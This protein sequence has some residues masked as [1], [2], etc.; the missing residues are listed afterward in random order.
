MANMMSEGEALSLRSAHVLAELVDAEMVATRCD[1]A[2][3]TQR[4][5]SRE[6]HLAAAY[7]GDVETFTTLSARARST[8]M[9]PPAGGTHER[10][11]RRAGPPRALSRRPIRDRSELRPNETLCAHL[12]AAPGQPTL[13]AKV[14]G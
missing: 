5:M 3:A 10:R 9:T 6:P 1:F 8:R 7:E 14:L 2:T 4:V 13:Y 11:F 12:H